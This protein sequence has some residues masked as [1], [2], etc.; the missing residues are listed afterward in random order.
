MS[1]HAAESVILIDDARL[2]FAPPDPPHK[3]EQW[4]TFMDIADQVRQRHQRYVTALEDVIVAVPL[5]AQECGAVLARAGQTG[6]GARRRPIPPRTRPPH[7]ICP[8]AAALLMAGTG[9]ACR[10]SWNREPPDACDV[11]A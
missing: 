10:P 6:R 1:A 7:A 4:P 11:V 9:V 3:R 5:H 8:L 2:F